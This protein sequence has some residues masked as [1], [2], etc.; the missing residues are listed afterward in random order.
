[1]ET[2]YWLAGTGASESVLNDL[3]L[4]FR[5]NEHLVSPLEQLRRQ[6]YSGMLGDARRP[7]LKVRSVTIDLLGCHAAHP[8]VA[9]D[10]QHS[11]L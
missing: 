5:E 11:L 10:E 2:N 6:R 4:P 7:N 8:V 3:A 9:A 1:M